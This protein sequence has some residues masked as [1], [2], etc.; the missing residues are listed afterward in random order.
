MKRS[1][2]RRCTN[3]AEPLTKA[4][5]K[6]R[7]TMATNQS[8]T[9]QSASRRRSNARNDRLCD[10]LE[11]RADEDGYLLFARPHVNTPFVSAALGAVLAAQRE[12][13]E[14]TPKAAAQRASISREHLYA[15]ER[16]SRPPTMC[17]L[18]SLCE[19]I[20][21]DPRE[22]FNRALDKMGYPVGFIPVRTL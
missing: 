7:M 5:L 11:K 15:V 14:L 17:V 3:T 19:A 22:L 8:T 6:P 21:I 20:G 16:G 18:L 12:S 2:A 10:I 13:V 1:G 9:K 4:T